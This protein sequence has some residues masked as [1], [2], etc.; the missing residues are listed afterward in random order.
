LRQ[1]VAAFAVSAWLGSQYPG[2]WNR[3]ET[4]K[5]PPR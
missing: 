1:S 5:A 4:P 3:V 2:T